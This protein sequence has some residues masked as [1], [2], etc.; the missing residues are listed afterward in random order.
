M[1]HVFFT[2]FCYLCRM[3]RRRKRLLRRLNAVG[4]DGQ[5]SLEM[6]VS[7][8]QAIRPRSIRRPH[9]ARRQISFLIDVLNGDAALLRAF[10]ALL[11][12]VFGQSDLSEVLTESG[13]SRA[14]SFFY[15]L[16]KRI[17]HKVLP[18][19]RQSGSILYAINALFY[20]KGDYT[21]I[22]EVED[23]VWIELLHVAG[24]ELPFVDEKN[25]QN[26]LKSLIFTSGR[27][28]SLGSDPDIQR[29]LGEHE[30]M[31]FVRQYRS[32]LLIADQLDKSPI[33]NESVF[34]TERKLLQ[35]LGLCESCVQKIQ[36][37]IS[38]FGTSL[39]QTYVMLRLQQLIERMRMILDLADQDEHIDFVRFVRYFKEL[40]K[41]ENTK[42]SIRILIRDNIEFLAYRI[43]EHERNTGE[44]YITVSRP[45]YW[46]MFRSA[47]GGGVIISFI[48]VIK[49]L[50]HFIKMA[51][52]WQ[53]FVYS[54]NY[55]L[56]FIG[57]YVTGATLATKQPAMTASAIA[58]SLDSSNKDN[59]PNLPELAI[60]VSE[61]LRS[62]TASFVGNL[63]V[64][65]PLA[66]CLA[67]LWNVVLGYPIAEGEFAQSLLD[68]Q[69]PLKSLSLLYACFTGVFLYLSGIISGYFDNKAIY[70]NIPERLR[71]HPGLKRTFS[72]RTINRI[73]NYT[74]KHLGG[75]MGNLCLGFF[76]GMAGF[77][78]YIFGISFDIRH[79]TISTANF[80]IGLQ[81]LGFAVSLWDIIWV[82]TG[83]VL[84]GFLNFFVSFALAFV[85]ALASRKVKFKHY[86][87]FTGYLV[88][89]MVRYPLD[90]IRAPKTPRRVGDFVPPKPK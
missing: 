23:T 4:K 46:K 53:G 76:L 31:L 88:R 79:I 66:L 37:Q 64:V 77:I 65:F 59:A 51:P 38:T 57:I 24:L 18:P 52:F 87:L 13:L 11:L 6:L 83:V 74:G 45:E 86:R 33:D 78:G 34:E 21:W 1:L 73:A 3:D 17:R 60:L 2:I 82:T 62:Q 90:F 89:L 29:C 50:F 61:V 22:A 48:A 30:Q 10:R 26:L 5:Y 54:A 7:L 39:H 70:G 36:S 75:M 56:G 84:I 67:W 49:N 9:V 80:A 27:I 20:K 40:V 72:K 69:N 35:E 8:V 41:N 15:E 55:A 19:L 12:H 81:G 42:N 63:M 14:H 44:H 32:A 68:N 28:S 85:T 16:S 58:S 43:A 47:M 25:R 71:E